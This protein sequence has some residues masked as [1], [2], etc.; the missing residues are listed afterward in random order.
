LRQILEAGPP[1]NPHPAAART[2]RRSA[3]P[4]IASEFATGF[5]GERAMAEPA[6]GTHH[7]DTL[8]YASRS[9]TAD[10][11]HLAPMRTQVRGWLAPLV[12]PGDA[13][14]D[15]VLAVSEAASN[16]VEHAYT[17]NT[18]NGTVELTFW[19]EAPRLCLE[20]VDHGTWRP[21]TDQPTH[22]G[23]GIEMMRRVMTTVLIH[24]DRRGT[25]VFLSYPLPDI[26]NRPDGDGRPATALPG[27]TGR[28]QLGGRISHDRDDRGR[29]GSD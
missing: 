12:L 16:C 24:Y 8:E 3:V 4:R 19:T 10:A 27:P 13:E 1:S 18:T 6:A 14:D 28:A 9:W 22:R 7:V 5:A 20:I 15:I 11:R 26:G 25:R 2:G 23:R 17:P 29:A 21:P